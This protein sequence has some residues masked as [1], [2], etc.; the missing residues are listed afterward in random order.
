MNRVVEPLPLSNE[1]YGN[2]FQLSQASIFFVDEAHR[3]KQGEGVVS[4]T[5][6]R[7]RG[8]TKYMEKSEA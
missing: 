5:S 6:S 7:F 8:A 4:P 2:Q 3:R 1:V